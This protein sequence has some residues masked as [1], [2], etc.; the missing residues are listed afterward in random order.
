LVWFKDCDKLEDK[1][2]V[3]KIYIYIYIHYILSIYLDIMN[4]KADKLKNST[5][6]T[7]QQARKSPNSKLFNAAWP[8]APTN[9]TKK[10]HIKSKSF[11]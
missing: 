6:K 4:Q 5:R 8:K 9:P 3:L 10:S 2:F 1:V 7:R 11:K